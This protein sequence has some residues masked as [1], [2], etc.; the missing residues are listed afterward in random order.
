M[1]GIST[2]HIP[3][4]NKK[5]TIEYTDQAQKLLYV[6]RI[7]LQVESQADG[8]SGVILHQRGNSTGMT[9]MMF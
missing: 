3:L 9:M 7:Y 4:S 6:G 1:V 5:T 2:C 8:R